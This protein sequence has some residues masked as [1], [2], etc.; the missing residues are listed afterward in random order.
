[1]SVD[2]NNIDLAA[3]LSEVQAEAIAVAAAEEM[4]LPSVVKS[5]DPEGNDE[6]DEIRLRLNS[7]P[8][9][10]KVRNDILAAAG[11]KEFPLALQFESNDDKPT[12]YT[13]GDL[14]L[15][16]ANEHAQQFIYPKR[17]AH[18][19]FGPH[20]LAKGFRLSNDIQVTWMRNLAGELNN[21]VITSGRHRLTAIILLLQHLGVKWEKQKI[22]VSTKVVNTDAEF[23]QLIYDNNDSRVMKQA[24]KRNHR[25]GGRGVQTGTAE[26]FYRSVRRVRANE[27]PT[28][29]AAACR[30]TQEDKPQ[31]YQDKLYTV[32][33]GAMSKVLKVSADNRAALKHTFTEG[34]AED[35][36]AR[37]ESIVIGLAGDLLTYIADGLDRWPQAYECH[38]APK[39]MAEAVAKAFK[40]EVPSFDA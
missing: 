15:T 33:A 39:V 5:Y 2:I 9:P 30:L 12:Y 7:K 35:V 29:F 16:A 24:E 32:A 38:S 1:M 6:L 34:S 8:L 4:G 17:V 40:V 23:A 14:A 18:V 3:D 19:L 36:Q 25:L 31:E 26:D 22:L 27:L 28:A 21:P 37:V 20:G 13:L 10:D 11:K